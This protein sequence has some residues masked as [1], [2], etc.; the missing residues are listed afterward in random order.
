[1]ATLKEIKY[2]DEAQKS[3]IN[4]LNKLADAVKV[5][6]GPKGRNVWIQLPNNGVKVTKDGVTVARSI[7]LPDMFENLAAQLVKQVASRTNEVAGDGTTTATVLAQ[8]LVDAGMRAIHDGRNPIDVMNKIES[9]IKLVIEYLKSISKPITTDEEIHT[10]ASI[11]SNEEDEVSKI[12]VE[13]VKKI[14]PR[15]IVSIEESALTK[16]SLEIV[17]GLQFNKGYRDPAFCTNT[18]RM[19]VEFKDPLI[20]VTDYKVNAFKPIQHIVA[21]AAQRNRP[22]IIIADEIEGE[23]LFTFVLNIQNGLK[24]AAV[25]APLSGSKRDAILQDVALYTGGE[26]VSEKEGRQFTGLNPEIILGS[27]E[28]IVITKD[29]TTIV[30]G[31]GDAGVIEGRIKDLEHQLEQETDEEEKAF[32]KERLAK[33][34]EG[35]GIIRVGGSTEAEVKE[36]KDRVE[37]S[38]NATRAAIEEGI[39]PG[40]GS[41]LFWASEQIEELDP[42]VSEALKAPLSQIARNAGELPSDVIGELVFSLTSVWGYDAR[43]KVYGD[44]FELKVCDPL[45]VVRCALENA[46]SIASLMIS[47]DCMIVDKIMFDVE[48]GMASSMMNV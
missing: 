8:A 38:L 45:K 4:G 47:N 17:K 30:G 3:R 13:A 5:T 26:Y 36:R 25:I 31:K 34:S 29:S 33:M 48:K 21:Y 43:R 11:A 37:D 44:M 19:V 10:I 28:K 12:V 16:T 6:L 39:L 41:A 40:G 7:T 32:L 35:V 22:L 2:Y 18:Q 24:I 9:D 46:T 20:F 42:Y 1:M 27:A 15:G 23:S 14:G